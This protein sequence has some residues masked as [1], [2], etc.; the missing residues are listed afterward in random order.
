M[1][2]TAPKLAKH[3]PSAAAAA[4]ARDDAPALNNARDNALN[5]ARN[6]APH[7]ARGYLPQ[8]DGLRALAVAL[9]VIHHAF[10]DDPRALLTALSLGAVGVRMFFVLSGF[11]ITGI[12]LDMRQRQ[13]PLGAALRTFYIRRIL[14]IF[15]LYYLALGVLWLLNFPNFRATALWHLFYGTNFYITGHP[16]TALTG[17]GHFWSL[18][19]EEQFY[20]LWPLA[21][22]ALPR[23]W[24]KPLLLTCVAGSVGY[25]LVARFALHGSWWN[26]HIPLWGCVDALALGALLASLRPA[27]SNADARQMKWLERAGQLGAVALVA[28]FALRLADRGY[29]F[30]H[31]T[32][33]LTVS[34]ATV[35]L[36]IALVRADPA[37]G[38]VKSPLKR[39]FSLRPL[40]YV[41]RISYGIY[42][43]HPM[44]IALLWRQSPTGP[45]PLVRVAAVAASLLV[46]A[47]SWHLYEGPINRLKDRFASLAPKP[48]RA[49]DTARPEAELDG[50]VN[51]G[52]ELS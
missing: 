25:R 34:L 49:A 23:R 18:A 13:L 47:L 48:R 35:W 44:V 3:R 1:S 29:K 2:A 22:L 10:L 36:L 12:L 8:L 42:V 15:P 14:R 43:V 19:V 41:G 17:Y 52:A 50:R 26:S 16:S 4:P 5:N 6:H 28:T 38:P 9:V 32:L 7:Q 11:L 20:L 27:D 33:E 21:I 46:A 24:L 37:N 40:A 31:A 30:H 51:L 45:T 39:L